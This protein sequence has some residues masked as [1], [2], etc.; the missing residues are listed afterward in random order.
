MGAPWGPSTSVLGA[1]C[2]RAGGRTE[3]RLEMQSGDVIEVTAAACTLE[4]AP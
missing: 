1:S 3:L 2:A 4:A